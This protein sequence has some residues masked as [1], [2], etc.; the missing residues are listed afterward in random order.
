[1]LD[2]SGAPVARAR[3]TLID[4]HGRRAGATVSAADGTYA[5]AVP[6]HGPYVLAARAPGHGP[7]AAPAT[8]SGGTY[9]VDVDLSLPS[10]T[11][12]A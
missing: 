6:A 10:E 2:A 5:V 12:T 4:R 11:V 8:H 3:V 9:S 7:L 1:M